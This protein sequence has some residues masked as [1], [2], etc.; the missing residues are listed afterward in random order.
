MAS[1]RFDMFTAVRASAIDH[2]LN[3]GAVSAVSAELI[4][5]LSGK[6]LER[7][8]GTSSKCVARYYLPK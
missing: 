6:V 1:P 3:A 8:A 2:E 4:L 5:L 7:K